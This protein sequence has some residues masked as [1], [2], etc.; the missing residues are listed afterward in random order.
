MVIILKK[1]IKN[2]DINKE[3]IKTININ[4]RIDKANI[5]INNN[6]IKNTLILKLTN[7]NNNQIYNSK[8]LYKVSNWKD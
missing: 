2:H 7:L 6:N 3:E 8:I 4:I 5:P 1:L